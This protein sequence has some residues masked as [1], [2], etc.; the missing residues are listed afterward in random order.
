VNNDFLGAVQ[1]FAILPDANETPLQFTPL[2]G[3]NFSEVN[4]APPPGDAAYVFQGTNGDIDQYH[5][6]I[7][8]PSEAYEISFVQHSLCCKLDGPGSHTIGSRVNST[9]NNT[10]QIGTNAVGNDYEYALFV[11]DTNP[12]TSAA[13]QPADFATTF[14]GPV[15]TS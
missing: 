15:I 9:T 6:T 5:Y 8:G 10:P 13:F 1:I 3:T 7:T 14:F 11:W 2:A 12:N 4:Q